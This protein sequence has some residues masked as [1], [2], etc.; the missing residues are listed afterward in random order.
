MW[1]G[2]SRWSPHCLGWQSK[3][4]LR[5]GL[6][7]H[8]GFF[9][10]LATQPSEDQATAFTE[11]ICPTQIRISCPVEAFGYGV[12]PLPPDFGIGGYGMLRLT[13]CIM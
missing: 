2:W 4:E 9:I 13:C 7:T 5:G 8:F 1:E 10:I 3:S 12:L 11:D 6:P